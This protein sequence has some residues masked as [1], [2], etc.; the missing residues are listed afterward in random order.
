MALPEIDGESSDD[1]RAS[2]SAAFD[3]AEKTVETPVSDP[4]PVPESDP[5]DAPDVE[6]SPEG[7]TVEQKA[8]RLSGRK[9]DEHGKLLP[10]KADKVELKAPEESK[11]KAEDKEQPPKDNEAKA[12]AEVSNPS[13]APPVTW[14]ADA[15][16][17]WTKLSPALKAAVLKREAEIQNGG[18]QWSEEKRRYES[19][20]DPISQIANEVNAPPDYVIK[21]L[22]AAHRALNT[23]PQLAIRNLAQKFGVNLAT[24]ASHSSADDQQVNSPDISELVRQAVAP[25][26]APIQQRFAADEQYKA[27]TTES[28]VSDFA[29]KNEHF[30]SVQSEIMALIPILKDQNPTWSNQDVLQNAYDRAVYA[31]PHTRAALVAAQNA[32]ADTKRRAEQQVK[33]QRART[34]STSLTGSSVI[35]TGLEPKESLRAEIEAAFAQAG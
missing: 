34:A 9:R 31:N 3:E 19:A 16:A 10:G 28:L 25:I 4:K 12:S 26:L 8:G 2:L 17:E 32:E 18:R 13:D 6:E 14:A 22:V 11:A 29:S 21:E 23:N 30:N 35:G 15:K 33:A 1:I 24:I 20:L 27:Q 5:S 7:E